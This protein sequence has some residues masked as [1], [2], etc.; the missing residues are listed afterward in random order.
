M[1]EASSINNTIKLK[2]DV[3]HAKKKFDDFRVW[4]VFRR[5]EAHQRLDEKL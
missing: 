1:D 2:Q 3:R 4:K 5:F